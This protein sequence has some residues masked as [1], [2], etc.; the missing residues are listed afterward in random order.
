MGDIRDG[1]EH[2][3]EHFLGFWQLGIDRF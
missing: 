1:Q 3:T 2:G